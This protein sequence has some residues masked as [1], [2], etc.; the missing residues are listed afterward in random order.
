MVGSL[1]WGVKCVTRPEVAVADGVLEVFVDGDLGDA[2]KFRANV[3]LVH[4][5]HRGASWGYE[6]DVSVGL[7]GCVHDVQVVEVE[8]QPWKWVELHVGTDERVPGRAQLMSI[9]VGE[10]C[11]PEVEHRPAVPEDV[12][13]FRTVS[14][15][16]GENERTLRIAPEGI[17]CAIMSGGVEPFHQGLKAGTHAVGND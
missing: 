4:I 1:R 7:I 12:A 16:P 8:V 3:G 13:V 5:G 11:I 6:I 17:L 15:Y 10:F 14:I 9:V 2:V